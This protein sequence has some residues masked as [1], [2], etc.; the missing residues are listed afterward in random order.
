M[1]ALKKLNI[2]LI[3]FYLEQF[4]QLNL[5]KLM[6]F[7]HYFFLFYYTKLE[8]SLFIYNELSCLKNIEL[9]HTKLW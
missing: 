2:Y 3:T 5:K 6:T 7:L 8:T 4:A 1:N 9:K